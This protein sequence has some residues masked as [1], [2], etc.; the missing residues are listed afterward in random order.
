MKNF[1]FYVRDFITLEP[2]ETFPCVVT[3]E[4]SSWNI[5]GSLKKIHLS[6]SGLQISSA[7]WW[8]AT[9]RQLT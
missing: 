7:K 8:L 3:L 9:N 4:F 2:S 1:C 6:L 5:P